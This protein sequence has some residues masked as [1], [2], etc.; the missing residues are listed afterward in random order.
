MTG[1]LETKLGISKQLALTPKLPLQSL[2]KHQHFH[3][4]KV[5]KRVGVQKL[6]QI[7]NIS[8][9]RSLSSVNEQDKENNTLVFKLKRMSLWPFLN[10]SKKI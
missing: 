9:V 8:T 4:S 3:V 5:K 1:V 6:E 2:L 7:W 10:S